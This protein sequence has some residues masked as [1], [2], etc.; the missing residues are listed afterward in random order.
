ML[1][2]GVESWSSVPALPGSPPLA[3]CAIVGAAVEIV[4]RQLDPPGEGTGMLGN[5]VRALDTRGSMIRWPNA[6]STSD[7]SGRPTTAAE[8]CSRSTST[9]C[10][11]ASDPVG[12]CPRT[13]LHRVLLAGAVIS[14]HQEVER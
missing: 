5:A 2:A 6:L 12:R 10:G 14:L 7:G 13:D 4:E 3:R 1:G 9:S 11:T 8:R